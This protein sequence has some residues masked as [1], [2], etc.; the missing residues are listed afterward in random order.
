MVSFQRLL[1][2]SVLKLLK[3]IRRL[4]R[5]LIKQ[6]RQVDGLRHLNLGHTLYHQGLYCDAL[7]QY[8]HALA[9]FQKIKDFKNEGT[10]LSKIG[11]TYRD[12]GQYSNALENFHIALTLHR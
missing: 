5:Y 9:L 2:S 11:S 3:P 6:Q 8:S 4:A 7:K 1:A 10:T 12:L